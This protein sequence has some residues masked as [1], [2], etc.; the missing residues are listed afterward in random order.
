MTAVERVSGAARR[1]KLFPLP[2]AVL[3]PGSVLPL[4]IF[5]PRYRQLVEDALATDQVFAM[6]RPRGEGPEPVP[7]EPMTCAGLISAHERLADGR[8]NLVLQGVARARIVRE[9]PS[10]RLYREVEAVVLPDAPYEGPLSEQV[11]QAVVSL[12]TMLPEAAADWVSQVAAAKD[13][14]LLADLVAAAVVADHK[15]R[16]RVLDALD[17]PRRLELVLE[18]VGAL[19]ARLGAQAGSGGY[20]N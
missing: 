9:L 19:L 2:N 7:L 11:R 3:F 14:G 18:D 13:G 15:R 10:A 16:A 6:A 12:A 1:L 8:F 4:H 17:V 5:E 20:K